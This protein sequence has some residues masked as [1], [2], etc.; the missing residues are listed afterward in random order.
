MPAAQ[1]EVNDLN[2]KNSNELQP[3]LEKKLFVKPPSSFREMAKNKLKNSKLAFKKYIK[4]QG[5][6]FYIHFCLQTVTYL[7]CLLHFSNIKSMSQSQA[8]SNRQ[9]SPEEL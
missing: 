4:H 3:P 2:S 9:P 1:F 6:R 8:L 5:I 7:F